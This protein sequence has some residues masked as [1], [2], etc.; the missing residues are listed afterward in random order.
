MSYLKIFPRSLIAKSDGSGAYIGRM[1]YDFE[2]YGRMLYGNE[3]GI[4]IEYQLLTCSGWSIRLTGSTQSLV[5]F[6]I[7]IHAMNYY[8]FDVMHF[9]PI[10]HWS[11]W[12]DKGYEFYF[13][14]IYFDMGTQKFTFAKE[15]P[16]ATT[17][18]GIQS[19]FRSKM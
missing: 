2:Q 15:M 5:G 10:S 1:T 3:T 8:L 14:R 9:D 13:E 6:G 4:A 17:V 18:D 16:V 7:F 12:S 11:K 19:L